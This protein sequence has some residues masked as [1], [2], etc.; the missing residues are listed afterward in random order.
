MPSFTAVYPGIR[1]WKNYLNWS[2]FARAMRHKVRASF[3]WDTVYVNGSRLCGT[4]RPYVR[5]K[6]K[7][8]ANLTQRK[9]DAVQYRVAYSQNGRSESLTVVYLSM[10]IERCRTQIWF[11]IITSTGIE[12][13]W[14]R[15]LGG[16]LVGSLVWLHSLWFLDPKTGPHAV[17]TTLFLFLFLGS[18]CYQISIH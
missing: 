16:W 10:L 18:C 15:E 5:L 1:Q 6:Y 3:F 17:V 4:W 9:I 2:T 12:I 14:S 7:L 11:P 8:S 13:L